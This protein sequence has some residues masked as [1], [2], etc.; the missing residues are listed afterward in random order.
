VD[1][2]GDDALVATRT[3]SSR[4]VLSAFLL[5]ARRYRVDACRGE[6]GEREEDAGR[7]TEE[8]GADK[9]RGKRPQRRAEEI[10][11]DTDAAPY[12]RHAG[13]SSWA[14]MG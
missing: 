11:R 8:A 6:H 13:A 10:E 4:Q 14:A 1:V 5:G 2:L 7:E 3:L 12:R 9:E